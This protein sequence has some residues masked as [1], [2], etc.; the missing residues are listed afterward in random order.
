MTDRL[1]NMVF[2]LGKYLLP[3]SAKNRFEAM[4]ASESFQYWAEHHL[5]LYS[6]MFDNLNQGSSDL[7]DALG[8]IYAE[9]ADVSA[10][11][12]IAHTGLRS[13]ECLAAGCL[14]MKVHYYTPIPDLKDLASR[15][16]WDQ[17]SDLPGV[18]F[19]PQAQEELL[20]RLGAEY[21]PECDWPLQQVADDPQSFYTGNPSFS[22]GCAA[23]THVMVRHFKPKRLVEIGS[24]MSSRVMSRAML[25]NQQDT[26]K[27]DEYVI[28]D[29]YAGEVVQQGLPGV[30]ELVAERVELLPV[31]FFE[32]LGEG[33][34]LFIDS[35]H[36]VR[37]GGDVNFLFLEVL[38][39]LAPG[40]A[41]HIHDIPLPYEYSQA[42]SANPSFR[43]FWTE[44]YLLQA[45]LCFNN[46]FE[47]LLA[48]NY[49][50]FEH[51]DAFARAFEH[52]DPQVHKTISGSF[53][54]R[55]KPEPHAA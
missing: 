15:G 33:D 18:D 48:A 30:T 8:G 23:S 5:F 24:G 6:K 14:P 17:V 3:R 37:T 7:M 43:M 47:V 39:R 55:R 21:G 31:S 1:M 9:S 40:V 11:R 20:L 34:I 2:R 44:S 53:W 29:P 28:V 51:S 13:E 22:F 19:R 12:A 16:V 46:E 10:V 25:M 50:M 32:D 45:F 26:G 4:L 49:L 42:L 41:V 38:P 35:G 36:C 54:I 52:Y 27:A